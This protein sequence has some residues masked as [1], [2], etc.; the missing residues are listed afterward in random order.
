MIASAGTRPT[1]PSAVKE[2]V[3]KA[4]AVLLCSSAVRPIPAAKG[5]KRLLG[6]PARKRGGVAAR[7]QRGQADPCRE[8]GE[9]VVERAGQKAAQIRAE[10]A[11][12]SAVDHVQAP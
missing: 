7:Q 12:N 6:A 9:A 10:G 5:G 2:L 1:R 4:V 8:G 11:Q 3:I